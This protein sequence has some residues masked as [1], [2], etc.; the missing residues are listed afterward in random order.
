MSWKNKIKKAKDTSITLDE[1]KAAIDEALS[2]INTTH[3]KDKISVEDADY[4]YVILP[5]IEMLKGLPRLDTGFYS[6]D[7][8]DE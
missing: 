2:V 8:N 3:F 5:L 6:D 4:G 1:L 7:D